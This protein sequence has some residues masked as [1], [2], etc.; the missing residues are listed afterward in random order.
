MTIK[1]RQEIIEYEKTHTWKKTAKHFDISE[2]S[3]SRILKQNS[4]EKDLALLKSTN[5]IIGEFKKL[6]KIPLTNMSAT[7]LRMIFF[8][9]SGKNVSFTKN[10]Y[11]SKIRRRLKTYG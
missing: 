4:L 1:N 2:M 6:L 10:Q 8:I 7:Q 9:L 3:I 11:I 5:K